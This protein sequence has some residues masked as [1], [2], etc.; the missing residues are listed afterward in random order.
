MASAF[1]HAYAAYAI[2]AGYPDKLRNL[3]FLSI[4]IICSIL[5]DA[6]VVS[7]AF[8]IPY[9]SFWGHRGFTHSIVFAFLLGIFITATFY[10]SGSWN[11]T[12]LKHVLFFSLCTASHGLLDALTSGGLG[13]AFFSPFNNERLFFPWRPIRVSPIGARNFF[14]EWGIRVIKS[15]AIWI[16][17]PFTLYILFIKLSKNLRNES[18]DRK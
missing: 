10:H 12:A 3:K 7:F 14:S 2:G 16:G 5:P 1:G 8:G 9:E 18:Q 6:D 13:V 11:K 4:G 15:E 17:I